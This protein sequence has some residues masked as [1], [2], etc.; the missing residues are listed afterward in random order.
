MSLLRFKVFQ[1]IIFKSVTFFFILMSTFILAGNAH[2]GGVTLAWDEVVQPD[3]P[4]EGYRVYYGTDGQSYPNKGYDDTETTCTIS[5]LNPG[6]KYYFV[7][8]AYNSFGDSDYSDPVSYTV[9]DVEPHT[10]TASAGS[11]GSISPSG[12]VSVNHGSSRSFTITPGSGYHV[13][14][15]VIDGVSEGDLNGY[16]FSN[17]VANH[18]I[19]ATFAVNTHTY[20]I[21]ASAGSNG[22]ISPSGAVSVNHGSSRSF[23]I[24]PGSGYQVADVVIDG[25]SKGALTGYT[26]SNVVAN[27][28]IAATFAVNTYTY[29]IT[30][31]AGSN[32]SIS[33]AG[34][35]TVDRNTSKTFTFLPD[36]GYEVAD[37]LVN[38]MSIGAAKSYTFNSVQ[39]DQSI[40][41]T[42]ALQT[43]NQAPYQP[44][45]LYPVD[46]AD[47]VPL[48]PLLEIAGFTD[49]DT[50]DEHGATR[51]QIAVDNSFDHLV[52][53]VTIDMS[54]TNNYLVNFL[55]PHGTLVSE[56]LYHWRAMVKDA[57]TSDFKWSE[58]SSSFSFITAAP[59]QADINANGV[60]DDME[61]EYSDLDNDGQNDNDQPFMRVYKSRKGQ[62]LIGINAVDG[63]SQ[64]NCFTSIDPKSI[65][66]E[67]RPQLKYELMVF[68]VALN[69]PGGT[70][71]FELYLPEKPRFEAKW[72]KYDPINGWYEF[73]VDIDDG[74]Y[75][76]EIT[77]GGFGDADG[78]TNGIV[79]DP[80]GLA[81]MSTELEPAD[82]GDLESMM[83]GHKNACFIQV[84]LDRPAVENTDADAL[85]MVAFQFICY[86]FMV[87]GLAVVVIPLM[88]GRLGNRTQPSSRSNCRFRAA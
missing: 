24:T 67:P 35:I 59:V 25:V 56:Q 31:S 21:T 57:H 86:G 65:P 77:D 10:I 17:V 51:W 55:V 49:P 36:E 78:V 61:P 71:R 83:D 1:L 43:E 20:T 66:D 52:L 60:P 53:D 64:I 37:V 40:S 79:V 76:I 41:V 30:A 44:V 75:F 15:V 39:S 63:V 58:W 11:N 87:L 47:E 6:Q 8:T 73:P 70:A 9:P 81:E 13:A 27:H 33:P 16:T 4:V 19:S 48:T 38:Q 32:G 22:S 54:S 85:Q 28:T 69:Q 82:T 68:N 45:L 88:V 26:F 3:N 50:G 42:F 34:T 5:G 7:V 74:K 46:G 2:S 29:K 23:T 62:S 14:D 12:A 84:A 18:T 80:I 72:Y